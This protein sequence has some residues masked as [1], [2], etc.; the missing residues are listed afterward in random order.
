MLLNNIEIPKENLPEAFAD[1]FISKVKS[2]VDEQVISE[3]VY[4]GIKKSIVLKPIS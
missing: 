4:N 2:I 3:T 1:M